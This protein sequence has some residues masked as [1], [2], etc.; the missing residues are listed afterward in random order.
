[1]KSRLLFC[2]VA[3][4]SGVALGAPKAQ[5]QLPAF[6]GLEAKASETV[7]VTL[8][9]QLLGIAARWLDDSDPQQA[10]AR[11]VIAGIQGIY[12]RSFTFETDFAYPKAEIDA[13][14]KQLSAPGWSRIVETRSRKENTD[15]DIYMLVEGDKAMGLAII[16]S[17]PREFTIVN[18]VGSIDLEKLHNI[19]GQ[20]GVPNLELESAKA[21]AKKPATK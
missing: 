7:T 20:F 9:P 3:L 8:G 6:E 12:V 11:K 13:V 17:E 15:V 18:I 4:V 16:A 10:E 21:P 14:R 5:L 1:M 19:E 2:F